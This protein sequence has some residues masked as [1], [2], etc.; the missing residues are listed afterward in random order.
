[1]INACRSQTGKVVPALVLLSDD[2]ERFIRRAMQILKPRE[3]AWLR[4]EVRG[5]PGHQIERRQKSN[6]RSVHGR[7]SGSGSQVIG[8]DPAACD[9]FWEWQVTGQLQFRAQ[10]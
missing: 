2:K 5:Q 10:E 8:S 6:D 1:M 3:F 7:M 4:I 9:S